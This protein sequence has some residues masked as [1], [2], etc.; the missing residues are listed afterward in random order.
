VQKGTQVQ[1]RKAF[2]I[3]FVAAA[4]SLFAVLG[5]GLLFI[6]RLHFGFSDNQLLIIYYLL[7]IIPGSIFFIINSFPNRSGMQ[8][9]KFALIFL[10]LVCTVN[11]ICFLGSQT[12]LVVRFY[13]ATH[14]MSNQEIMEYL[15]PEL[16][17][18]VNYFSAEIPE[19][20]NIVLLNGS[21]FTNYHLF[22]RKVYIYPLASSPE[23]IPSDW[24]KKKNIKWAISYNSSYFRQEDA[25]L[26]KL[27]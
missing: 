9:S 21:I 24:L 3:L 18:F 6:T 10:L 8:V 14:G 26:Y 20:D 25:G 2:K 7:L 13:H 16:F 5:Y 19:N 22:P 15:D 11:G 1:K 17:K 23:E 12:I 27:V 4:F